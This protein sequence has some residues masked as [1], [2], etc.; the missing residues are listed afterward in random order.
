MIA[1]KVARGARQ[2]RSRS[3]R[4]VYEQMYPGENRFTPTVMKPLP[5]LTLTPLDVL[6][7]GSVRRESPVS[8]LIVMEGRSDGLS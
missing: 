6:C 1:H 5:P 7:S 2:I 8:V 3:I 4:G